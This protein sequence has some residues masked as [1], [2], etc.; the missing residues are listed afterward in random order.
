MLRQ[1]QHHEQ[2]RNDFAQIRFKIKDR[3]ESHT[4]FVEVPTE[5]KWEKLHN[6]SDILDDLTTEAYRHFSQ[7]SNTSFVKD[8]LDSILRKILK[9][10]PPH[11]WQDQIKQQ[12][13]EWDLINEF[14]ISP[15]MDAFIEPDDIIDGFRRWKESTTTS[16]SGRNLGLYKILLQGDLPTERQEYQKCF[17]NLFTNI[18]NVSITQN[19]TLRLWK[20]AHTILL[21]KDK[22]SRRVHRFRNIQIFE[23]DY[24]LTV[25]VLITKK[26]LQNAEK[27]GIPDEQW[28]GRKKRSA[29]DL[30]L[31]KAL[32]I[33]YALLS[34]HPI[35]IVELDSK[36]CYDRII[37]TVGIL[38]LLKFGLN[39]LVALWL[40][41]ILDHLRYYI[42]ING[43]VSN[44]AYPNQPLTNQ[45]YGQGK[46]MA[47]TTWI[48][49]DAMI[50]SSYNKSAT[51]AILSCPAN[52]LTITKGYRTLVDDRTLFT[53]PQK[54]IPIRQSIQKNVTHLQV[55]L[56][57]TGGAINLQKSSFTIASAPP[58][59]HQTPVSIPRLNADVDII[60]QASSSYLI[61]PSCENSHSVSLSL[62]MPFSHTTPLN[63]NITIIQHNRIANTLKEQ[64]ADHPIKSLGYWYKSNGSQD[65][66]ES[67]INEM[68][69]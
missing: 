67:V 34:R 62:Y 61:N 39:P 38:A 10:T 59:E 48:F 27:L 37:K 2:V 11:Q 54:V 4:S 64:P 22:D 55:A 26:L 45:G 47:G 40:L 23:A 53:S 32:T 36:A 58:A 21:P 29:A 44:K 6:Q 17:S 65:K 5:N 63:E 15:A 35:G 13:H 24:N 28:G 50:T 66:V 41:S 69:D 16:P 51:P 7:A 60:D 31:D 3:Y 9:D 8:D 20:T 56:A 68:N 49:N 14:E 46:T 1:I 52:N 19:I 18:I 25:K 42:T 30:G 33:D 12:L 57:A 43:E